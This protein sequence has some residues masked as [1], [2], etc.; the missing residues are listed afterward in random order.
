MSSSITP[1]PLDNLVTSW[2]KVGVLTPWVLAI[3][4][5]ENKKNSNAENRK[6][7]MVTQELQKTGYWKNEIQENMVQKKRNPR[8]HGTEKTKFNDMQLK[9]YR[10]H[11][12]KKNEIQEHISLNF[13]FWVPCFLG[14]RFSS[15]MVSV[16]LELH[17]VG[18][19]FSS[20]QELQKP[21]D[22]G[23]QKTK[24]NDMQ[25]KN[26]RGLIVPIRPFRAYKAS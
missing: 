3:Q 10:N 5:I 6:P 2:S 9:N 17:I 13:V 22:H 23:T 25:L 8:K 12:T 7:T 24:S 26:Y 18:F 4:H 16:I 1:E 19:R 21:W 14:F 20:T 11:G 15:T